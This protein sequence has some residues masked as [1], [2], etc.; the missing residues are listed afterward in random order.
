MLLVRN[1]MLVLFLAS[2]E[3]VAGSRDCYA[4]SWGSW[5]DC[6]EFKPSISPLSSQLVGFQLRKRER[7]RGERCQSS[8]L[9]EVVLCKVTE[10]SNETHADAVTNGKPDIHTTATLAVE[11]DHTLKNTKAMRNEVH[12]TSKPDNNKDSS[13]SNKV[14]ETNQGTNVSNGYQKSDKL[15]IGIITTCLALI[16]IGAIFG[17][18]LIRKH[19]YLERKHKMMMMSRERIRLLEPEYLHKKNVS[20]VSVKIIARK[21]RLRTL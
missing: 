14:L 5:S 16:C 12:H 19:K 13:S 11:S 7:I 1:M 18:V 15:Y 9:A 6:Q 4:S 17:V 21:Y 10:A 2:F 8:D 3:L 20:R